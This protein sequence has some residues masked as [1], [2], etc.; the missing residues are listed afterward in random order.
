MMQRMINRTIRF[1]H[2]LFCSAKRSVRSRCE[3]GG[4]AA[5]PVRL[6]PNGMLIFALAFTA[7]PLA[8]TTPT[9]IFFGGS[10]AF[11]PAVTALL[12]AD[13]NLAF[14]SASA[15]AARLEAISSIIDRKS[16]VYGKRVELG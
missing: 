12:A 7:Q 8:S 3:P 13:C 9:S 11:W 16:V 2:G 6:V 1:G 5:M 10:G 14:T 15:A 4:S